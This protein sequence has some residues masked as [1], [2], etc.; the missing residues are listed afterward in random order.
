M[1]LRRAGVARL[2]ARTIEYVIHDCRV[3]A[4]RR[5][6]AARGARDRPRESSTIAL[7]IS[8][9][10]GVTAQEEIEVRNGFRTSTPAYRCPELRS[11]EYSIR[12]LS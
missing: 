12:H 7:S 4:L 5:L 8:A 1:A 11:S 6:G 2:L 3:D 10:L 9:T